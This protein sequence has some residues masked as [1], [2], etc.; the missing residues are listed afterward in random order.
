[1]NADLAEETYEVLDALV[2]YLSELEDPRTEG[3]DLLGR[4]IAV[5]TDLMEELGM[6]E[7]HPEK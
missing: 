7:D 6:F 2:L 5:R 4:V 3:L 1:M